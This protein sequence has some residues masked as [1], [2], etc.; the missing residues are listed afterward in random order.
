MPGKTI[1]ILL[2]VLLAGSAV[3]LH[4]QD[5]DKDNYYIFFDNSWSMKRYDFYPRLL[6]S[7]MGAL[8]KESREKEYKIIYVPFGTRR[9]IQY[10][11]SY[12][13]FS[14]KIEKDFATTDF[15][16]L[17]GTLSRIRDDDKVIIIS[18]GEHDISNNLPFT[19][20][21]EEE[22]EQMMEVVETLQ[23]SGLQVH[24]LHILK[25]HG[26][27]TP[28]DIF[29]YY[30]FQKRKNQAAPPGKK[31]PITQSST[32][33]AL[34]IDFMKKLVTGSGDYYLCT[35]NKAAV[36]ALFKIFEIATPIECNTTHFKTTIPLDITFGRWVEDETEQWF[37]RELKNYPI[38]IEGVTREFEKNK[39]ENLFNLTVDYINNDAYTVRF[40]QETLWNER[41][42]SNRSEMNNCIQRVVDKIKNKIDY[43]LLKSPQYAPRFTVPHCLISI[44]F[45]DEKLYAFIVEKNFRLYKKECQKD[46]WDTADVFFFDE[47]KRAYLFLP[48]MVAKSLLITSPG[49]S[50]ETKKGKLVDLEQENI[51]S[52]DTEELTVKKDEINY[53]TISFD[54]KEFFNDEKGTLL[55][56]SVA[57]GRFF[58]MVSSSNFQPSFTFFKDQ[59]YRI[60][61]VPDDIA[62]ENIKSIP[63]LLSG[64]N[65]VPK[66]LN[67]LKPTDDDVAFT[68]WL[69]C[70]KKFKEAKPEDLPQT[71]AN[72]TQTASTQDSTPP[73][74]KNIESRGKVTRQI[75]RSN[76]Y[77]LLLQHLGEIMEDQEYKQVFKE[78]LEQTIKEYKGSGMTPFKAIELL[79]AEIPGFSDELREKYLK[80][81]QRDK[82]EII[83]QVLSNPVSNL[84]A[85][86]NYV[87]GNLQGATLQNQKYFKELEK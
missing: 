53:P 62:S 28:K 15:L 32:I 86:L 71:N 27:V 73:L 72:Q 17:S 54:F 2:I 80:S 20:L 8:K 55:F 87:D 77:F 11:D 79:Q 69:K 22:L 51:S 16:N 85:L 4:T 52:W 3:K 58:G 41:R 44:K 82:I 30:N 23:K 78:L 76:G 24:V 5:Q 83:L 18:D 34:T 65:D 14:Q 42:I 60:Y 68:S 26:Q 48:V 9:S 40:G 46:K 36:N 70:L 12:N 45:E 49:Q 10:F 7:L 67:L 50:E 64:E 56:F 61:F 43:E 33:A 66:A 59:R 81:G 38:C 35:D 29:T 63:R 75:A 39:T 37:W 21:S 57:T 31:S 6:G 1:C 19:N 25:D 47:D 84:T 13:Q 74:E